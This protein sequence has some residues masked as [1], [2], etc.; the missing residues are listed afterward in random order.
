MRISEL[1]KFTITVT[2]RQVYA[3]SCF[4]E[5]M[6]KCTGGGMVQNGVGN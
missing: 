5:F 3:L 4:F 6:S 1:H 2:F